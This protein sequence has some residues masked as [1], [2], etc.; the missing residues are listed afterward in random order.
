MSTPLDTQALPA[1]QDT[2]LD[3]ATL[4]RL[5]SDIQG[6]A[7]VDEVLLKGGSS[8][9]ASTQ[10]HSLEDAVDALQRGQ[11]LG[12]QVRYRYQGQCWW[13]TLLRAPQGIRLVRISPDVEAASR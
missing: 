6:L 1:L 11:V 9:M 5:V 2:V 12:V 8:A 4:A 3:A 13:D 7:V 10:R